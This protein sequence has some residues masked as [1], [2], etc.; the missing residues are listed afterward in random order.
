MKQALVQGEWYAWNC[1]E[2]FIDL[3]GP[4]IAR[5][6]GAKIFGL[7]ESRKNGILSIRRIP[8]WS[9]HLSKRVHG[10]ASSSGDNFAV[11]QPAISAAEQMAPIR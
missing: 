5:A 6:E 9:P 3:P 1:V 7:A 8:V 11:H 4:R 2:H 10:E